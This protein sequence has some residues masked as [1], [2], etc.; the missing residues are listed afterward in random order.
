MRNPRPMSSAH[1]FIRLFT[2][3]HFKKIY[4]FLLLFLLQAFI[5][6]VFAQTN[7]VTGTV[8][9]QAGEPLQ[10]ATINVKGKDIATTSDVNGN[11]HISV[12]E[13]SKT[14][15]IS[16]IGMEAKE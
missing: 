14:L 5:P 9:N 7:T 6:S 3:L 12:P 8:K 15:V 2:D 16:F 4:N 1:S 13:K 11:F 10:G